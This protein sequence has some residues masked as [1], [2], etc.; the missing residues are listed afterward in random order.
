[1]L[2]LSSSLL[3]PIIY[4]LLF[5]SSSIGVVMPFIDSFIRLNYKILIALSSIAHM[6][7]TSAAI[8]AMNYAGISSSIIVSISYGL[9]SIALFLWAGCIINKS[10]SHY[11]DSIWFISISYRSLLFIIILA[12]LSLPLSL[13]FV[14][15]ILAFYS[16]SLL[17]FIVSSILFLSSSLLSA[18]ISFLF[19]NRVV[20]YF[21]FL[22]YSSSIELSLLSFFAIHNY[23]FGFIFYI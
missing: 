22:F 4:L 2:F 13:S 17:S 7:M 21:S 18:I 8:F 6:N 23:F 1:M 15:E 5:L 16:I 11:V 12:N 14:G 20:L 19:F 9:S 3:Y 10:L